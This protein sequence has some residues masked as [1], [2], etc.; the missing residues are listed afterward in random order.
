MQALTETA[1]AN[2]VY[3]ARFSGRDRWIL[4]RRPARNPLNPYRPWAFLLEQEPDGSGAVVP[5]AT[6]FL[7][8]RECPWR[9]VMCDLWRN[10][11]EQKTPPG[12]ILAQIEFALSQ[13]GPARHIKLYNSGSFFDPHAIPPEDYPAIAGR[14]GCFERVIVENHPALVNESCLRF[15]DLLGMELEIAM[16]LETAHP[17]VLEKLNKRVTLDRFAAAAGFLRSHGIALRVFI[18]VQPPFMRP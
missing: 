11:L 9:C 6:V 13:M 1:A 14:V 15:R 5:V 7:T 18:L 16:G 12:A 10:T 17:T 3:P 4:S 8:N 2:S